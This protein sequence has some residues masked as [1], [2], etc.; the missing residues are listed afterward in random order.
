MLRKYTFRA[1]NTFLFIRMRQRPKHYGL[2]ID[3]SDP[4]SVWTQALLILALALA[5]LHAMT[6]LSSSALT[7]P[8]L[9][10]LV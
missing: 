9:Q 3:V 10:C 2:D 6:W 1:K 4:K 7:Q 8:S 5:S